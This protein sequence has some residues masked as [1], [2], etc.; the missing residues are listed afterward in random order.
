MLTKDILQKNV[1]GLTDEQLKAI[2]ELSQNDENS[3]IANKI[4]EI[5]TQYD[6]DIQSITGAKKDATEKTYDFLKRVLKEDQQKTNELAEKLKKA[7]EELKTAKQGNSEQ[8]LKDAQQKVDD[9]QSK[10]DE[11]Q[12]QLESKD[13]EIKDAKINFAI[14]SAT[15]GLELKSTIPATARKVLLNEAKNA[16][17]TEYNAEFDEQGNLMFRDKDGNLL[18]NPDNKMQPFA[19]K[20]LVKRKLKEMDV[21]HEG[22]GQTGNGSKKKDDSEL[23]L[24]AKTQVEADELISQELAKQGFTKGTEQY[25]EQ[26]TKLREDYKVADLP[27]R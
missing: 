15:S 18:T 26:Q 6:K 27:L 7:Q 25:S 4:S 14:D 17:K 24:N 16:L 22:N 8:K 3:V 20:D 2:I 9:L 19:P 12:K 23:P 11:L 21:L 1:E 10:Y 13:N 5:H